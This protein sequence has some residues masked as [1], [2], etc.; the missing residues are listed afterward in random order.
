MN[1]SDIKQIIVGLRALVIYIT[2]DISNT[3][4]EAYNNQFKLNVVSDSCKQRIAELRR[5]S[6][7]YIAIIKE[8]ESLK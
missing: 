6:M 5:E 4:K 2:L 1:S 3:E 8:L 7:K